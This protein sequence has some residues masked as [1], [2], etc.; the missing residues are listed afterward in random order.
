MLIHHDWLATFDYYNSAGC[1]RSCA[2]CR[3]FKYK[4]EI[5]RI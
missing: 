3:W 4:S 2:Q 5:S 1:T